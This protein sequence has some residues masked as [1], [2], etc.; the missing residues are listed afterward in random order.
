ME[1][2]L[3]FCACIFFMIS[4]FFFGAMVYFTL[5]RVKIMGI[6]KEVLIFDKELI[7]IGKNINVILRQFRLLTKNK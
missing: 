2:L 5:Q 1:Y 6:K 7:E 3:W 4:I